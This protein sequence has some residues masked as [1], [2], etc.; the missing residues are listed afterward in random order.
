MFERQAEQT[1]AVELEQIENVKAQRRFSSFHFERLQELNEERPSSSS[2]TT[3]PSI[4]QSRTGKFFTASA[5]AGKRASNL[6]P[7]REINEILLLFLT[8][9][10]R[11]P[12][13]FN[14]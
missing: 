10:A 1:F 14:S 5:I 13:N 4:T 2:A 6:F 3:S 12:S 8:A 9:M 11:M 7:L